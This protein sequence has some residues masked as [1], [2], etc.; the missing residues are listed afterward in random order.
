ME[1][2]IKLTN[3]NDITAD[4]FYMYNLNEIYPN[5]KFLI[6]ATDV[7]NDQVQLFCYNVPKSYSGLCEITDNVTLFDAIRSSSAIPIFFKPHKFLTCRYNLFVD[8]CLC[9]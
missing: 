4:N 7:N 5:K 9:E 1:E 8:G 3:K 2:K 6:I